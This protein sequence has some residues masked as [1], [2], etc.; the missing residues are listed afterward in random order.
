MDDQRTDWVSGGS[1]NSPRFS[2]KPLL[3]SITLIV[4][5]L[6]IKGWLWTG[7][8]ELWILGPMAGIGFVTLLFVSWTMI[9]SGPLILFRVPLWA[10]LFIGI[11][12]GALL[13]FIQIM[14]IALDWR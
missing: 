7:A 11:V 14:F 13:S 8:K 9:I 5:G 10:V 1:M 4:V 6:A 3:V 12:G 2:L